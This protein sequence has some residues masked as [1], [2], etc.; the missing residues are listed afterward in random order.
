VVAVE[1]RVVDISLQNPHHGARRPVGLLTGEGILISS[2]AVYTLLKRYSLQTL[3]LRHSQINLR[4]LAESSLPAVKTAASDTVP[5]PETPEDKPSGFILSNIPRGSILNKMGLRNGYVVSG[6][7]DQGITRPDQAI[8][9]F[10][11]LAEGSEMTIQ[12]RRSRGVRHR[13]R[14]I[15]LNIE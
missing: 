4:R 11:T 7:N 1:N 2:S 5:I 8:E 15:I 10:R 3:S 14:Q 6:L 13:S 9:F 12:V